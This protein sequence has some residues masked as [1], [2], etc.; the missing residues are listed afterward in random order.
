M[1]F[2]L[3][4]GANQ[5]DGL[6]CVDG[7]PPNHL[8]RE[9]LLRYVE[10]NISIDAFRG[11]FEPLS[12]NIERTGNGVAIALAY[13]IDGILAEASSADWDECELRRE[14]TRIARPFADGTT[15]KRVVGQFEFLRG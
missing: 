10:Q 8:I 15:G 7:A 5:T 2:F 12:W 6:L 1:N 9:Q 11:W 14:L 4:N 13:K 3:V